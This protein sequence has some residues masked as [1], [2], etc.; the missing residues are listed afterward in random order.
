MESTAETGQ[1]TSAAACARQHCE[2]CELQGKL[3][4]IHKG[5]NLLDFYVLFMSFFIP[6]LAGMI[7]GGHRTALLVWFGLAAVFFIYVEARILCR[8]CP[9]YA[10]E[11]FLLQCHANWGLPKI[12][13]FDPRP[14]SRFEK[15]A[16]LV[17]VAVLFLY[18]VPFFVAA[19]Q[20]LLLVITTWAVI[21]D[22]WILQRK[23]C[24]RCYNL[25][26]PV[27]RVPEEVRTAFFENYPAFARAWGKG[28]E[29]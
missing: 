21:A 7:L 20:W 12:P 28:I 13:K 8:H 22:A 6:F 25:S 23:M 27:N 9:H 5:T 15:V 24:T 26:C 1:K 4:C 11:G 14:L 10:E 3:L 19:G 2:G 17:W 29:S 16:W 18:H